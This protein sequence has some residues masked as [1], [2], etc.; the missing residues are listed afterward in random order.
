[1]QPVPMLRVYF[2]IPHVNLQTR[3]RVTSDKMYQ[4][5]KMAIMATM[6]KM[7]FQLEQLYARGCKLNQIE[8]IK[9]GMSRKIV[10]R[11]QKKFR[12]KKIKL[13]ARQMAGK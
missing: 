7:A 10:L 11:F 5:D 8:S 3:D 9:T 6:A 13:K 4:V 12:G 1:M 2:R